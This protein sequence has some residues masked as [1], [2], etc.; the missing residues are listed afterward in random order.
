MS[1]LQNEAIVKKQY[2]TAENLKTRIS[3]HE[4]Y[5]TNHQGFGNWIVEKYEI[6]ENARIL[7]LGCG[8]GDMWKGHLDK[9]DKA[10]GLVL[11][12]FSEGML[13]AAENTLGSCHNITYQVVDIQEIPFEDETFDVVIANM[14]LY[15]V[16]NLQKGLSE[17]RRV[18][19]PQG[20]FYC[21]TYGENGI[22][23]FVGTLL[24]DFGVSGMVNTAF[25]L[26]NG[27]EKLAGIFSGVKR[28]D[29]EDSLA[30]TD[31][32]DLADY[33]YSLSAMTNI[34]SI[35]RDTLIGVLESRKVNGV[36]SIPKEYG[37]F[38]C[39]KQLF[40]EN[41]RANAHVE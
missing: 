23:P 29:Y 8:T 31:L 10:S 18:L 41:P 33:L 7:E 16:P 22:V 4:K 35:P 40:R 27:A 39:G 36:L 14:M 11:T 25:T 20:K 17:V 13:R 30:V 9:L 34:G 3:I 28:F 15:H 21:A 26:Q 5:S 24:K 38:V 1:S 12:D 2:K 37:M 19:K 6:P 32:S